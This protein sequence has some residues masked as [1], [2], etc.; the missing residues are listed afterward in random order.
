MEQDSEN[1][2]K[3]SVRPQNKHLK[4]FKKGQSGNPNGHP[5]GKR[6]FDTIYE[7]A[8]QK[9]AKL[10]STTP[11]DL[12]DEMASKAIV[13]SRKGQFN[14]YRDTMDRRHGT[15]TQKAELTGKDGTPLFINDELE[16]KAE[17]AVKK[18]L[19]K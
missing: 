11:E 17:E 10:N 12:E 1:N 4:P 5:K 9:L 16:K 6:N 14:F 3:N 2:A 19:N 7:A 15:A 13:E 18:F 8:L